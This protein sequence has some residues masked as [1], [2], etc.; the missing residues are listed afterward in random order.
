MPSLI[1]AWAA[2]VPSLH[3]FRLQCNCSISSMPLYM[4]ASFGGKSSP[5]RISSHLPNPALSFGLLLCVICMRN[6]SWFIASNSVN[7]RRNSS[8]WI[9]HDSVPCCLETRNAQW[10]HVHG[11]GVDAKRYI[12]SKKYGAWPILQ[13][14]K[15]TL[16][17]RASR[18]EIINSLQEKIL[19]KSYKAMVIY[20]L[21][22]WKNKKKTLSLGNSLNWEWRDC[23]ANFHDIKSGGVHHEIRPIRMRYLW[24]DFRAWEGL[25][26]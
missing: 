1:L 11:V 13:L 17:K 7:I 3:R 14:A 8:S 23:S 19:L 25:F 26:S 12:H 4:L 21:Q 16:A 2:G 20:T 15:T 22:C 18:D 5:A 24:S 10:H 6:C 9:K